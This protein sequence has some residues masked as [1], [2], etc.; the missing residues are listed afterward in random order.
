MAKKKFSPDYET[1]DILGLY[2]MRKNDGDE[3][4]IRSIATIMRA[5]CRM[6]HAVKIP[7]QYK[8][9]TKDVRTPFVRDSWHRITSSLVVKNP[10]IH[11]V[12]L[13][14]K[15]E[16]YRHCAN[17]AERF[18]SAMIERVNK[19]T[20][21]GQDII[22]NLDAQLVRDGESCLSVFHRPQAWV[23]FPE[24]VSTEIQD[25]YKKG[26]EFPIAWRAVDRMSMVYENGEYGDE[27]VIEYGE[28]PR[29]YLKTRYNMQEEGGKLVNPQSLLEGKPMPEGLQGSSSWRSVKVQF[30]NAREWHVIIDGSPAPGYP[31]PNPYAPHLPYF[32]AAAHESESLLYSLFYLVPR[33]DELL[34]MKLNWSYLGAYPNPI[35]ESVPNTQAIMGLEPVGAGADEDSQPFVWTPGKLMDIPLGKSFKFASPPP[36]GRDI[37]EMIILMKSLVD[38]AGI[39]SIMRG[40]GAS[41][42]SGY[43]ANQQ[44]AAAAM[45]YRIVAI[46]AQRQLEKALE[47][48]H[49]LV[50]HV[51][52]QTVY[53]LG[54]TETNAKTMQPTK[55]ASETWLAL[56]PDSEGRYMAN[57]EKVGCVQVKYRPTLPT[58]QQA[59]AMIALQLTNATKPLVSNQFAAEEYLQIE[60]YDSVKSQMIVEN[61]TQQGALAAILLQEALKEAGL[62]PATPPPNPASDLV[63][64]QGGPLIPPGP[65]QLNPVTPA[66]QTVTGTPSV[67]GLNQPVIPGNSGGRTA[68]A[69]PGLPPRR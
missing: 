25:D 12:P 64:T 43:L 55:K 30:F 15:R 8:S 33:L 53:A 37:N 3:G 22:Y 21:K 1:G 17:I 16:D 14:D 28:Y 24:G 2:E 58:D 9:I 51:I 11:V 59:N 31:K 62:I 67:R 56:S 13:D 39:P 60:D 65:G 61:A 36:V 6:E 18:D 35:V 47:F 32:R 29:S 4:R 45:G 46:S 27:W 40:A 7:D 48:T 19:E 66:E 52:R 44:L 49:W 23:N 50:S 68:G 41:G 5:L 38:I 42:D 57:L 54:W 26:A 10:I 20:G 69:Y 34:T 63:N